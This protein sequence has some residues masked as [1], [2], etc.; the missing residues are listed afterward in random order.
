MYKRMNILLFILLGIF[1]SIVLAATPLVAE[2]MNSPEDSTIGEAGQ[3]T[4]DDLGICPVMGGQANKDY[5]Y[6]Y[7]DKTYYFCCPG[8]IGTFK[9]DPEKYINKE[10]IST[11]IQ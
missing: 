10:D 5:S 3:E 2:E 1:I 6:V 11:N 7:E 9:D 8:C 4:E